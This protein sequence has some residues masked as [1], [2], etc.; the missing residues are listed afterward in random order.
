MSIIRR[1]TLIFSVT[2]FSWLVTTVYLQNRASESLA[3]ARTHG[4]KTVDNID[5]ARRSQL[6]L[7]QQLQA[8]KSLVLV[9][10]DPDLHTRYWNRFLDEEATVQWLLGKLRDSG[11]LNEDQQALLLE[12]LDLHLSLGH[13]LRDRRALLLAKPSKAI[14]TNALLEPIDEGPVA[15]LEQLAARLRSDQNKRYAVLTRDLE[16]TLERTKL[17][18]AI[19]TLVTFLFTMGALR[20]WVIDPVSDVIDF[21]HRLARGHLDHAINVTT[22]GEIGSMQQALETMRCELRA[23]AQRESER[24]EVLERARDEALAAQRT[25]SAFIARMSHELRTPLHGIIGSLSLIEHE[26]VNGSLAGLVEQATQCASDLLVLVNDVLDLEQTLNNKIQLVSSPLDLS[27]VLRRVE[28]TLRPLVDQ[29]QLHL[30]TSLDPT[31][32]PQVM[33]D[34]RRL[35]QVLIHLGTNAVK[36]TASG[37]VFISVERFRGDQVRFLV[38]DTGSGIDPT[39]IDEIF[40]P[41]RQLDESSTRAADGAGLGLALT[42][43]LVELMGGHIEVIPEPGHGTTFLFYVELPPVDDTQRNEREF[44]FVPPASALVVDDNIVNR[45][46]AAALLRKQGVKVLYEAADGEEAVS[47]WLEHRPSVV[48]M[49]LHMPNLDGAEATQRIRDHEADD[50]QTKIIIM[51]ASV[52]EDDRRRPIDAGADSVISK[53]TPVSEVRRHI[54]VASDPSPSTSPPTQGLEPPQHMLY[55]GCAD[56]LSNEIESR[57]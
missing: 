42:K 55:L 39:K 38:K 20:R 1:I 30:M 57:T 28:D 52:S 19:V 46:I 15:N 14:A 25:K 34:A 23:G 54:S 43:Q 17:L 27:D 32:A 6:H 24:L 13:T 56:I 7:S 3:R 12:F 36:F 44:R 40:E 53:P 9:G 33:G 47:L 41:F 18:A 49:D 5:L 8:W 21:A 11:N 2:L 37:S 51:T 35:R 31:L 4:S 16:N 29:K 22:G 48:L 50:P 26:S 45:R 10:L